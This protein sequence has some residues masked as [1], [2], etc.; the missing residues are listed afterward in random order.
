M[1]CARNSAA[2]R[3][4]E[5]RRTHSDTGTH[6]DGTGGEELFR[7]AARVGGDE[8]E[9]EDERGLVCEKLGERGSTS[10]GN[11]IQLPVR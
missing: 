4:R 7:L 11:G 6:P 9:A 2:K 10:A 8:R 3:V 1:F 5:E